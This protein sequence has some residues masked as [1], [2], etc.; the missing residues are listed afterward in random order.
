MP[1]EAT[2]AQTSGQDVDSIPEDVMQQF[3]ETG[4]PVD[5]PEPE[6]EAPAEAPPAP[7]AD[8]KTEE[9]A[10]KID[11]MA[12]AI[13]QLGEM[14]KLQHTQNL[15]TQ[16]DAA[17]KPAEENPTSEDVK[18]ILKDK[19]FNDEASEMLGDVIAKSVDKVSERQ[20]E[21][22]RTEVNQLKASLVGLSTQSQLD[23][24]DNHTD[25]MLDD[26]GITDAEDRERS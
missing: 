13:G 6:P 15:Q 3:L 19:G 2:E 7:P 9:T 1:E 4:E 10:S 16:A 20:T 12:T 11:Q 17:P 26:K 24:L 14:V 25:R 8:T 18:A 23:K 21:A 5:L 22:M